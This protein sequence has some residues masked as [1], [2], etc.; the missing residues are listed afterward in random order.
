M[1]RRT[2]RSTLFRWTV[3]PLCVALVACTAASCHEG[4][5]TT[6]RAPPKA[7]LG[8]DMYGVLCD[9]VGASSLTEDLSGASYQGVC[10]FDAE[11]V[12]EDE[13]DVSRLPAPE[14]AEAEEARRLALA[15]ME[16]MVRRRS[17]LIRAINAAFPDEEI[18]DVSTEEDGDSVRLHDAL[19]RFS[20]DITALYESNP[21]AEGGAPVMPAS[22][23][24]IGRHFDALAECGP[25]REALAQM[26]GRQGYR[27]NDA[28]LGAIRAA[29]AYPGL[30]GL[31]G[32]STAVIGPGG[33]AAPQL[34]QL[35]AVVKQELATAKSNVS[36]LPELTIDPATAQPS[37]PRS[38]IEFVRALLLREDTSFGPVTIEGPTFIAA[39]DRRGLA[40]PLPGGPFMDVDG[41]GLADVDISGRF[42]TASPVDPPF[43]VPG[44]ATVGQLDPY[45]RPVPPLYA[46]VDTSRTAGAALART[47][48]P[49][50]DATQYGSPG[51]PEAWKGE[52]ESLMY[53]LAGAYLLYGD[54]EDAVYDHEAEQILPAGSSCARCTPYSRFRGEDSPVAD[55]AHATG[56][57]LADP[58]SDALLVGVKDLL[59]NHEQVVAR[60][61][62]AA[63]R[64]RELAAEHDELAAAGKEP[65]AEIPY[66]TPIWDEVGELVGRISDRPG[67]TARLLQ[68]FADPALVTPTQ[69]QWGPGVAHVGE[70]MGRFFRTRDEMTYD[71]GNLNG[72]ALNVTVSD[73]TGLVSFDD[74]KTPVD[75]LA[76]RMGTNRSI[77]QRSFQMIHDAHDATACNKVDAELYIDL[78]GGFLS[79]DIGID[80]GECNLFEF[81]NVATFYVDSILPNGHPKKARIE[82]KNGAL[83]FALDVADFLNISLDGLFEGGSG[84]QGMT[85][86]PTTTALNRLVFF[87][88]DSGIYANLPDLDP[89]RGSTNENTNLF[90]SNLIEPAS[91]SVC[92]KNAAGA[93]LCADPADLL[94]IR[95]RN[96]IFTWERLGFL[97]YLRPVLT[98]FADEPCAQ[99]EGRDCGEA[100]FADLVR[101]L[102]RHW[103]G[104]DHGP[105]CEKVGPPATNLRYCSEAGVYTYEP[106]AADALETDLIPAVVELSRTVSE[107]SAITVQRGPNA[108]QVWTGAEV[109]EKMTRL[110]FSKQYAASVGMVDRKGSAST[111][112]VDGTPQEQVTLFSLMAD[113]LHGFD[114]RFDESAAPDAED[115]KGQW[116]RARSQIVDAIFA[117]QGE[118]EDARFK[119]RATPRLLITVI[120]LLREQLNANCPDREATGACPW[121]KEELGEKVAETLSGPLFAALMDLKES[122]RADEPA[123]RELGRLLGYLLDGAANDAAFRATLASLV[124]ISQ[125]V[126]ND[127]VLAPILQAAAVAAGPGA[128]PGGAGALA[129]A[130]PVL[131]ATADDRFDRYHVLDRVLP[132]LV[133][134]MNAGQGPAPIEVILDAI[135][136]V[137]RIDAGKLPSDPL[138]PEDY[139]LIFGSVRDFLVDETR[140]LEQFYSVVQN[141]TRK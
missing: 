16:A 5:D 101:I 51:D 29:L 114:R 75:L 112:W 48:L 37:R 41:D 20:Q 96:G 109:L 35:L 129:A 139:A 141:R 105:E 31:S 86:T 83:G 74:P 124:D 52:N 6:R 24:A 9:R 106:L 45:G 93:S 25:A 127:D 77:M 22:T 128:D 13:V 4:L 110:T 58:E 59:E 54:R 131:K 14:G 1:R 38:N 44:L 123:R 71:P 82:I 104:P 88:A 68:A 17:D 126:A 99:G 97:D 119:N 118:G 89:F 92:P 133:T 81:E 21:Y 135:A 55:L 40:V 67:M 49:L 117:V 72:P 130:I 18:E 10:H 91:S 87:G 134:P 7:T 39:R 113:A 90:V 53:T 140:G 11:G 107:L 57:L 121:A 63:L 80:F 70:T 19:L 26:W 115:R 27:P 120:D 76:P 15:K 85:L 50:T 98:G 132:A 73:A 33:P 42:I 23:Q 136:E 69:S 2:L 66:E 64:V 78:F 65:L 111:T 108:G 116:K 103:S 122:L 79:G 12:Y 94:R 46:Y 62:G 100:M 30:R 138:S 95:D 32:S 137:N 28:V 36:E 60:L 84:I 3:R 47:L 34:E 56:Q 43:A 61:I 125:V 102:N 8:D